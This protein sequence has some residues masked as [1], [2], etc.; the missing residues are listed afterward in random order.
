MGWW[1]K[2]IGGTCGFVLG[3]PLG[4]ILGAALGH[5]FDSGLSIPRGSDLGADRQE[6]IQ[7][8]FFTA[9]FSVMGHVAKA[10]GRVSEDEIQ[11]ARAVMTQMQL[12]EAQRQAAMRL[13][14][15]GKEPGF[16]LSEA[17]DQL[18]RELHRRHTLTQM[19]LE[20]QLHAAY[21]DGV[22]HPVEKQLLQHMF[23]HLGFTRHEFEHLETLVRDQR[24]FGEPAA[25]GGM[26]AKD[27]LR[28]A[29]AVLGVPHTAGD[30]D[31]KKAYR[32]LMNQHH[33]D[34]LVAKGLPEEM[35]KL[36]ADKTHE[37]RNAYETIRKARRS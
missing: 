9:T 5:S 30:A 14:N 7:T 4:A 37:I 32:R 1:G 33:P 24:L 15:E 8:A 25:T 28:E 31:I 18:K 34:K 35:M 6:R 26:T 2:L 22:L 11:L 36:A 17:L 12:T 21:A 10:D 20:I 3:G 19:F 27:V 16:P 23:A 13:F 29:Y